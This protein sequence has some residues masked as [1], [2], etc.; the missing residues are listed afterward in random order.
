M[1]LL[2]HTSLTVVKMNFQIWPRA[3]WPFAE[4]CS[5][6]GMSQFYPQLVAYRRHVRTANCPPLGLDSPYG[7]LGIFTKRR[8]LCVCGLILKFGGWK[9][10]VMG[11]L[12]SESQERG[13]KA[14]HEMQCFQAQRGT[15]VTQLLVRRSRAWV[16]F[17]SQRTCYHL[18]CHKQWRIAAQAWR[19]KKARLYLYRASCLFTNVNGVEETCWEGN[20]VRLEEVL[21]D[22]LY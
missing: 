3:I 5:N 21:P 17:W 14:S 15:S 12:S 6:V 10:L 18:S 22:N 8:E 1:N 4:R 13:S 7:N 16:R 11:V 20:R 2:Q 9:N 19:D